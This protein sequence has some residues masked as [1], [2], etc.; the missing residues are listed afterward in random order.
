MSA[1]GGD[2]HGEAVDVS[3]SVESSDVGRSRFLINADFRRLW[4]VQVVSATGDWLGFFAIVVAAARVGG[5]TPEAAVSLVMTARVVPGLFLAPFAGVLVD[6]FDRRRVMMIADIARAITLASLPFVDQLWQLVVA[7]LILELFTLLWSPAKEASVPHIVPFDRLTTA[8]SLSMVA[9]YGTIPVASLL[10][11]GLATV[12]DTVAT[13]PGADVL[14]ADQE[15]LAF[16]LDSLTFLLS[17][18]LIWGIRVPLSPERRQPAEMSGRAF[19][20]MATLRELREGWEFIFFNPI[21]RAV[22]VAL[23]TGLIGG[24]MLIPLGPVFAEEVLGQDP[25]QGFAVLQISLGMGVAVG[26]ISVTVGQKTI[27]KARTFV[28]SVFGAG[29]SLL[30]A[31]SMTALA[32][33]SMLVALLGLFAGAVYVLGFTLLHETVDD[34]FRGRI[35]ASL[36]A[37]VRLCLIMALAVGPA[38]AVVLN[39]LSTEWFDKQISVAG[40]D[41][42]I[43]GVRLTLWLAALIIVGAGMLAWASVRSELRDDGTPSPTS[44]TTSEAHT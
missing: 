39:G 26:V 29:I 43:P 14:R 17:A 42:F 28:L 20:P 22:N 25:G 12:A 35:F 16:Y 34:E 31:A 9:A 21:V 7:S 27:N 1:I 2:E 41:V 32:S 4:F 15:A 36:Y 6:R 11:F 40:V 8:N 19:D 44:P 33:A 18:L 5:G 23:A 24:G 13:W 37:L 38:L 10:F 3:A 30:L